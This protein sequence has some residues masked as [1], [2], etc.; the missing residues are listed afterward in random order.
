MHSN[1][2]SSYAYGIIKKN[3]FLTGEHRAGSLT[4]LV[5]ILVL[6]L[7]DKTKNAAPYS[8]YKPRFYIPS[9]PLPPPI[10][11]QITFEWNITS[12]TRILSSLAQT[13]L[14]SQGVL[15]ELLV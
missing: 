13:A 15:W 7:N 5:L 2:T 14:G 6:C 12:F 4:V 8:Q 9:S 3:G 10:I 1:I 11:T